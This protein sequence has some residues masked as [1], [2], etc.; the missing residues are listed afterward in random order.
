MSTLTRMKRI[1]L[2]LALLLSGVQLAGANQNNAI[3]PDKGVLALVGSPTGQY[4]T[5]DYSIVSVTNVTVSGDNGISVGCIQVTVT[6]NE[7]STDVVTWAQEQLQGIGVSW[8]SNTATHTG[9]I[10]SGTPSKL[11]WAIMGQIAYSS[12]IGELKT[13]PFACTAKNVIL[14]QGHG[15]QDNYWIWN[16]AGGNTNHNI[17]CNGGNQNAPSM[18]VTGALTT[19]TFKFSIGK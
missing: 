9:K 19:E 5:P 18:N 15:T 7:G 6:K 13:T 12:G 1:A 16:N 11:N 2:N 8:S 17:L 14:A 10:G 3:C 4:I